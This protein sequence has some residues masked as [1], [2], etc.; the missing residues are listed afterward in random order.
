M[1]RILCLGNNTEDT[2][3]L[4][5][6]LSAK[7]DLPCHGLLSDLDSCVSDQS[8][9][10]PGYYHTSVYDIEFG[11][12]LDICN[13]FDRVILLDQPVD[14]WSHPD[15]FYKTLQLASKISTP[16]EYLD[17]GSTSGFDFFSELVQTNK[18]FCIFPFIELLVNF[19][20]TT[21]CCRSNTPV[22]PVKELTDFTRDKNY[23]DVRQKMLKGELIPE[24][25]SSCY[26]LENRGIISARQQETVEWTNRLQIRNIEQLSTLSGPAY[27]EIRPSNKCNLQCRMCGPNDSHLIQREYQQIG[28]IDKNKF[29][30][31]KNVTGFDIVDFSTAKKIYV[32]GGEPTIMP[33]FYQFLDQ[34]I[35]NKKTDVEF[36]VNTNGTKLSERFK[37]QLKHFSNFHFIFSID[38]FDQLNYYIR[39]PSNWKNIVSNLHYLRANQHKVTVNTTVSIYNILS[40]H[41]LFKFIDSEFPNTLIHC[42]IAENLSPFMFPDSQIALDSLLPIRSL[43][44][45]K[46]DVLFAS[47]ID[48][49]INHFQTRSTAENNLLDFFK[50]ND[51]LDQSRGVKLQDYVPELE[52]YRI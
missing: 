5:R 25:C 27:Y 42:Q 34:C 16:V 50:F 15:A 39:W 29:L 37:A 41:E 36:L 21:V 40:L 24:H 32:A 48:G 33:E 23:L 2:D 30:S 19:D 49:Y 4:T 52:L 28:L 43:N 47:S 10:S 18:S 22:T 9:E 38:G 35:E 13:K 7:T 14:H 6:H 26:N 51:K 3:T 17:P 12:L 11:K 31:K 20:F 45:Y 46:N 8:F 44:C 1:K